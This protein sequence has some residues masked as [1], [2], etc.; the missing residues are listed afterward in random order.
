MNTFR[1]NDHYTYILIGVNVT[2]FF[3]TLLSPRLTNYLMLNPITFLGYRF[4]WTPLTYMFTHASLRHI[5]YNMLGLLFFGPPLEERLGSREFL[6][7]YLGTGILSGVVTAGSYLLL[8]T[9]GYSLV[10]ASAAVY[11]VLLG[12]ATFYPRSRIMLLGIIPM[13]TVVLVLIFLAIAVFSQLTGRRDGIS[14]LAH[15][16]GFFFAWV[17]F[18]VRHRINPLTVFKDALSSGD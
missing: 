4:Y 12:F 5:L 2:V 14:H 15:L 7:F 11:A 9:A 17:Y 6:A 3:L 10:G 13:R 1:R 8:G 18:M 16:A